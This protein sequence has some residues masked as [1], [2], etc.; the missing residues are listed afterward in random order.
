MPY[1]SEETKRRVFDKTDG[2][3]H[4]CGK[5]LVF[6]NYGQEGERG[7]WQIEHSH[8]R[9]DGGVDDLRNLRPACIDCNLSKQDRNVTEF[10]RELGQ[11][12][13]GFLVCS[14]CGSDNL[15]M[16]FLGTHHTWGEEYFYRCNACGHLGKGRGRLRPEER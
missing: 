5:R 11:S 10:R 4:L 6:D 7:A 9:S 14:E 2:I 3:C 15:S 1:Y 13:E 12:G 8:A 16:R